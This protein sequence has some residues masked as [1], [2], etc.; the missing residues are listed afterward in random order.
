MAKVKLASKTTQ[1]NLYSIVLTVGDKHFKESGKTI[2]EAMAKFN[3]LE[4]IDGASAVITHGERN[5]ELEYLT[6]RRLGMIVDSEDQRALFEQNI[7][8]LLGE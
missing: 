2:P 8:E 3:L 4:F 1:P 6:P 5:C 7:K